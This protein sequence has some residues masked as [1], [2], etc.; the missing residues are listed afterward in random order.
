MCYYENGQ[1]REAKWAGKFQQQELF[2]RATDNCV[3]TPPKKAAYFQISAIGGGGGGGDAGYTG[4]SWVSTVTSEDSLI[5]FNITK[6]Q[7]KHLMEIEE[8]VPAAE[9]DHYVNQVVSLAGHLMGYANSIGSG[10][11]GSIGYMTTS[12]TDICTE[13]GTKD[14]TYVVNETTY[15]SDGYA[16]GKCNYKTCTF[17]DVC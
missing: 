15:V 7:L 3:F 10:S 16:D 5:P 9:V 12:C 6:D 4:G 17:K 14:E 2:N 1:L 11:G 8:D 13:F